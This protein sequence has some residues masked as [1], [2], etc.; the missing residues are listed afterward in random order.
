MCTT[1]H[2][3]AQRLMFFPPFLGFVYTAIAGLL[4][5]KMQS[6]EGSKHFTGRI[7]ESQSFSHN[8][9]R[10]YKK[11]LFCFRYPCVFFYIYIYIDYFSMSVLICCRLFFP[12]YCSSFQSRGSSGFMKNAVF[13]WLSYS[14]VLFASVM[15]FTDVYCVFPVPPLLVISPSVSPLSP[16]CALSCLG[17][18]PSHSSTFMSQVKSVISHIANFVFHSLHH[19]FRHILSLYCKEA[20]LAQQFYMA[21]KQCNT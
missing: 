18:T 3:D 15:K 10:T 4:S 14:V 11:L 9:V 13:I 21:T 12:F 7:K 2:S 20:V 16:K 8:K 17:V 19:H 6:N 5:D 1:N